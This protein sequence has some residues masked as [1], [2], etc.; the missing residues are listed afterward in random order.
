MRA[1]Q[2]SATVLMT[3]VRRKTNVDRITRIIHAAFVGWPLPGRCL[4]LAARAAHS[5][6]AERLVGEPHHEHAHLSEDLTKVHLYTVVDLEC[7][8]AHLALDI[9]GR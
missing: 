2:K 4:M 7:F 5:G 9:R 3:R 6:S 8:Q 1:S